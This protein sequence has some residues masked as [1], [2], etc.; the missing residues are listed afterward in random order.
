MK[1]LLITV[2]GGRSSA[3]MARHVQTS[4][5]YK[6]YEKLFLFCNTGME[7]PKTI[8][9]LKKIE[10]Y[11]DI[12]LV[13][14][15]GVYSLE[16]GVGVG[17]KAVDWEELNMMAKP[18]AE[19]IAHKNKGIF[20]GMPSKD[21]PFCSEMLKTLPAKKFADDIFGTN[22]YIKAIGFRKEDMPKRISWAEIKTDRTR[23]F[24]LLTDFQFPI[25]QMELNEYWDEQ[26]F[27]LEIH[28]KFGNCE[29]CW[30]KSDANLIDVIRNGTRFIDWYRKM[31]G[32]YGNTSFR[33]HKSIDDLVE[34]SKLPFTGELNF[35]E[36]G[37]CICNF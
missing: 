22:N 18:F 15:E 11:W 5:K 32:K 14:I 8:E 17:Y 29:L 13:K 27:K 12:P 6:N 19:A 31:E 1:N 33:G 24:P 9:F 34:L 3:M 4:E 37:K 21:A 20:N 16:M 28:N 35:E 36:N 30:K 26:P 2:S 10:K 25:G 23:I 7:H